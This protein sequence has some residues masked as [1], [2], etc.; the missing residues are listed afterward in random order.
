MEHPLLIVTEFPDNKKT[1]FAGKKS[2]E[3][4]AQVLESNFKGTVIDNNLI[5]STSPIYKLEKSNIGLYK[6]IHNIGYTNTSLS[7]SLLVQPGS[8]E[9][10]EH[11]PVSFTLQTTLDGK[12][13]DL[14]FMFTISR[15]I[16]R[17]P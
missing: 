12:P 3:I 10:K 13:K 14:D 1:A 4:I 5:E 7:V 15:V 2:P 8:F 16:S 9:I 6:V 11:S 17:G